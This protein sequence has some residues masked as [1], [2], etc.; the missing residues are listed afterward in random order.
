[1]EWAAALSA[2]SSLLGGLFGK[3]SAKKA[4]RRQMIYNDPKNIR[5][6]FEAA[7]FN[8]LLGIGPQQPMQFDGTNYMGSAIASAGL[9]LAD[10]M[11][12]EKMVQIERDRLKME[13]QKLDALVQNATIRP[14]SGGI[15][16]G[17]L[18]LP[19]RSPMASTSV[20]QDDGVAKLRP[21]GRPV[22][23]PRYWDEGQVPVFDTTGDMIHI[24]R[25]MAKRLDIEPY[26][27]LLAEDR[28]AVYGD[29]GSEVASTP[30]LPRAAE[31]FEGA[32][33]YGTPD[34]ANERQQKIDDRYG[35]PMRQGN[36]SH[37]VRK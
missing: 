8:P 22:R 11:D 25:R 24:N 19:S 14:R 7:G 9:A 34:T 21:G 27:A 20:P 26:D 35:A 13:Q 3:K 29:I 18:S 28:E 15:Y 4:E 23:R 6:R 5:K 16:A 2:G 1:M 30:R 17:T 36:P 32:L 33:I 31:Q 37:R 12:K 10:G